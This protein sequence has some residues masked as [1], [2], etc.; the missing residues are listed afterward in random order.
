MASVILQRFIGNA[1]GFKLRWRGI[2]GYAVC[3]YWM[4]VMDKASLRATKEYERFVWWYRARDEIIMRVAGNHIPYFKDRQSQLLLN[5]GCGTGALSLNFP[6]SACTVNVDL[7]LTSEI[8]GCPDSH[9][10]H[11]VCGNALTLPFKDSTFDIVFML[12]VLEHL[13]EEKETLAAV[14]RVLKKR[15]Y[16]IL[17]VPAFQFLWSK[18]DDFAG[19]RRRYTKSSLHVVLQE[20]GFNVGKMSYFNFFLFPWGL[21]Y[22]LYQR[23][24]L[25]RQ[26]KDRFFPSL[27]RLV[28][29]TM[30]SVFSLEK[31]FLPVINFPFGMSL[32][33]VARKT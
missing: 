14:S 16:F 8:L 4:E 24:V 6:I 12:D 19:H 33:C 25:D 21:V 22:R 3:C 27:P 28:N 15:G 2:R 18:M 13:S 31:H 17:T 11:N 26:T 23:H 5:L 1:W 9:N 29:A 30:G 32:L 20:G 7:H 10:I